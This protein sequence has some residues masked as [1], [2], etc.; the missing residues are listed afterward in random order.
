MYNKKISIVLIIFIIC[1]IVNLPISFAVPEDESGATSSNTT[2][3]TENTAA[4]ASNETQGSVGE[5]EGE[6]TVTENK[7]EETPSASNNAEDTNQKPAK[8][9]KVTNETKKSSNANLSNLGFTPTDFK[10]FKSWVTEYSAEVKNDVEQITVYATLA[11]DSN[12]AKITS[13]IGTHKLAEGDNS[14]NIVVT[15]ED[16]TTKTY[17]INVKR[18][19]KANENTVEV[20]T[21]TDAENNKNVGL[22][23]IE[24]VGY[25][26]SPKFSPDIYEYKLNINN[27]I[28]DLEVKAEGTN[29]NVKVE[30]A[31]NTGL[32][33][34][35]N[36]ITIL[37]HNE[38][39]NSYQTYQIIV[40]KAALNT[41]GVNT[42]LNNAVKKAN[43]IRIVLIGIVAVV[44]MVIIIFFILKN[45]FKKDD[46]DK[47][48]YDEEEDE[49]TF[50]L[51]NE[52][53]L[54]RRVNKEQFMSKIKDD[55]DEIGF[56]SD[57]QYDRENDFED[58]TPKYTKTLGFKE[59][60]K[61][62]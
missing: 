19:A 15:A 7:E 3:E 38:E 21:T 61:H 13:G 12:K 34:G 31:G 60:G 50:D 28:S 47:Y 51:N 9:T 16:G 24:V 6:K 42:T 4:P 54:F 53:T 40:N 52:E 55:N 48:E 58:E 59:K 14:I 2:N 1:M 17:T 49:D 57:V 44:I 32:Q 26:I 37:V 36:T 30:I 23:S 18:E 46:D 25:K 22:K 45:K 5:P 35:E 43:I 20:S 41:D 33:D 39:N 62:F 11:S 10:G 27:D 29:N 8:S 56:S